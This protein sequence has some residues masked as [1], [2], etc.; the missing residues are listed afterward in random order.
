MKAEDNFKDI[1][2]LTAITLDIP[3]HNLY[4]QCRKAEWIIPRYVACMIDRIEGGIKHGIIAKVLNKNR[5]T[6]Y[7][8]ERK[9]T[10]YYKYWAEYR[11]S[12]NKVLIA[13]KN[14]E[15]NKKVFKSNQE[16]RS[17][18]F[19]NN[20]GDPDATDLLID[21]KSGSASTIIKSSYYGFSNLMKNIKFTLQDYKYEWQ[22]IDVKQ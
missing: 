3:E 8:Y 11:N 1:C 12:F 2:K 7:Y 5:G 15:N 4:I 10:K 20:L 18:L 16:F 13:Y 9:H 22:I 21:L 19:H 6:I 14:I 17:F